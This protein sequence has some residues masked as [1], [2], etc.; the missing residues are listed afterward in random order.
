MQ[1]FLLIKHNIY[2]VVAT[3][4]S[5][6]TKTYQFK[7]FKIVYVTQKQVI[8]VVKFV[9]ELHKVLIHLAAVQVSTIRK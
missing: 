4:V 6:K 8:K 5:D 7:N 1:M 2:E 3:N 9:Q